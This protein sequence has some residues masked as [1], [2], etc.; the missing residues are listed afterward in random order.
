MQPSLVGSLLVLTLVPAICAQDPLRPR[1]FTTANALAK[2]PRWLSLRWA[3]FDTRNA[4]PVLVDSLRAREAD[5]ESTRYWLLQFSG[6]I[7]PE[8]KAAAAGCGL[9]VLDYVPNYAFVVRGTQRQMTRAAQL[10]EAVWSD[11]FHPAYRIDPDLLGLDRNTPRRF[12][13]IAFSGVGSDTLTAQIAASRAEIVT[14]DS[15]A[16]ARWQATVVGTPA[17]MLELARANDVQ[18]IQEEPVGVPRNDTMTWT[19]QTGILND[20]KIWNQGLHGENQVIGHM[21]GSI[22]TTSCYFQDTVNPVGPNH[23]KILYHSG[24]GT[25]SH[26]THTAGTAAGDPFP[27]NGLTTNRGLAYA[28]KI[29]HSTS[30][31]TTTFGT[32]AGTHGTYGARVHTNSWGND[33]NSTYDSFCAA[34]DTFAWTNED[35]L[36]CFAITNQNRMVT[37]PDVAKNLLAVGSS[38]NGTSANTTCFSGGF[39]P[40]LDGRRKPEVY[41]PGC[42]VVSAGTAACNTAALTGS[43]MACPST[44]A[45]AALVRQ[46][47]MDGFYPS[48]TKTPADAFVPTGA[49]LKAML[50]NSANDMTGIASYP[51]AKEGWGK[52]TLD[53]GLPFPGDTERLFVVDVRK[54]DG[55]QTGKTYTYKVPVIS[56][57]VPL[58]ITLAYHDAP[59]L[60]NAANPVVNDVDLIV[61]APDTTPYLG[62]AIDTNTG[63]SQPGGTADA[64]NN[65]ERVLVAAPTPGVWTIKV[66]ATNVPQGAQGFALCATGNVLA[67]T[68]FAANIVYGTGKAG[69]NGVPAIGATS[70]PRVGNATYALTLASAL[71]NSNLGW[72]FG[73]SPATIAFD[74]GTLLVNPLA[75]LGLVAS[76]TGSASLPIPVPDDY[77]LVNASLYS[78]FWVVGDPGASGAGFACSAGLQTRIGN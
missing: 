30:Y 19:V 7:R 69:T 41:T 34:V 64:K 6:P 44:T 61:V 24:T 56:S 18:W 16:L 22:L 36:V 43:S 45:A 9:E 66:T 29:A 38:G 17:Q 62:N 31:P 54:K 50:V 47:F 42:A 27:I 60:A 10:P 70:P 28:A 2:A 72:F 1:T 25:D 49:L 67:S 59:G 51:S 65:V 57:N 11:T 75:A 77:S 21:D 58:R 76:A 4:P 52:L 5:L 63:W 46:Y 40:T 13:V 26:G 53:Q 74:G 20:R 12:V 15:I 37:H 55:L 23:R 3:E 73:A 14:T 33:T 71:A 39:G 48:G 78:Q 35:H 32:I 68:T 8:S